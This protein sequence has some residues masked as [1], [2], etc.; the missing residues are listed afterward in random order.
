MPT[1]FKLP[2]ELKNPVTP[3]TESSRIKVSVTAV[4]SRSTWPF[5]NFSINESGRAST[6]TFR[7]KDR[8]E[9]GLTPSPTPQN[10]LPSMA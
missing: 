10:L 8:A 2:S 1:D 3:T 4:P 6:S 9:F 5:F 7:P